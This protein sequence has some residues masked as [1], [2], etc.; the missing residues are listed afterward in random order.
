ML[1]EW[2]RQHGA[3]V[4]LEVLPQSETAEVEQAEVDAG[5]DVERQ[6]MFGE[7][8]ADGLERL[9]E[10][11]PG[12]VGLGVLET[13]DRQFEVVGETLQQR[14]VRGRAPGL[15]QGDLE[16]GAPG[17]RGERD[18]DQHEGRDE[19]SLVTPP[20]K[21]A[22]CE[23]EVVGPGLLQHRARGVRE[24]LQGPGVAVLVD[25][26]SDP[27]VVDEALGEDR[28]IELRP[29]GD[30]P[31]GL[32]RGEATVHVQ[33]EPRAGM[34]HVLEGAL[35]LLGDREGVGRPGRQVDESVVEGE[36]QE[37]ALPRLD[38]GGHV[39]VALH[40]AGGP[41]QVVAHQLC[42]VPPLGGVLDVAHLPVL[43]E[44]PDREGIDPLL[45]CADDV[46]DLLG[47]FRALA[48]DS[49][50][51]EIV[52]GGRS[53]VLGSGERGGLQEAQGAAV[54]LVGEQCR[55]LE[56]VTGQGLLLVPPVAEHDVPVEK[57][58]L[59]VDA[60]LLE[61]AR[62]EDRRVEARREVLGED[63]LGG[64]DALGALR[65]GRGR[66]G[67][68]DVSCVHGPGDGVDDVVVPL[69]TPLVGVEPSV[70]GPIRQDPV[71]LTQ[72]LREDRL[73]RLDESGERPLTVT[74]P[75]EEPVPGA[76]HGHAPRLGD[77]GP[78]VP[79]RGEH[80]PERG[81]GDLIDP[82]EGA[83][84]QGELHGELAGLARLDRDDLVVLHRER[85]GTRDQRH[86]DAEDGDAR[87]PAAEAQS[88]RDLRSMDRRGGVDVGHR[89]ADLD[90]Q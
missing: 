71:G 43:P 62:H 54:D 30:A 9:V 90:R 35:D 13:G 46:D 83:A 73:L 63:L 47:T 60:G 79:G 64:A 52:E 29:V 34:E 55:G 56:G 15:V 57:P 39:G 31:A 27:V 21:R 2:V 22:E 3:P 19:I 81:V 75:C 1:H 7:C 61:Q 89:P 48:S 44:G 72:D 28:G 51:R 4:L 69:S 8:V 86:G 87:A 38:A 58:E 59:G 37:L 76:V 78:A 85:D 33:G 74:V 11:D 45:P 67:I 70:P 18:G 5:L 80:H 49:P 36:V 50:V 84:V 32:G 14:M 53:G 41:R 24:L 6:A 68:G 26:D 12:V 40:L 82:H 17:L 65:P 88:Q 16:L 10:V 20:V 23:V 66:V 77:D 25:V 42:E